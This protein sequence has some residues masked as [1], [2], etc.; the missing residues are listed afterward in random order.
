M[1]AYTSID[2]PSVYFQTVLYTGNGGTGRNITLD[3]NSDLQPDWIWI[4]SRSVADAP[5]MFDSVR[6]ATKRLI[7]SA[8]SEESTETQEVSAFNTDGFTIGNSDNANKNTATFVA[9]NW[10]AGTSFTNDASATSIGTIDSTGSASNTSGFSVV[11]YTGTGSS[12]T[13]K[14]GLSTAPSMVIIKNRSHNNKSWIIAQKSIGYAN[15][16]FLNLSDAKAS[17]TSAFNSTAPTSSV[18]T[19]GTTSLVNDSGDNYIA[20]CFADVK[21]YSKV[22]GSYTGNGNADGA[23]IYTGFKPAFFMAKRTDANDM[24]WVMIDNKR[25]SFNALSNTLLANS[26]EV[27]N[28]GTDRA[29]FL[30]QGVKIKTTSTAWNASGAAFIFMAFA[31]SPFVSSSGVPTTAR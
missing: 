5:I 17:E 29:D 13:I 21:G 24:P 22:S 14:H 4:K 28:T 20:Y 27:A 3:G 16:I 30:S 15:G 10:K 8:G 12:G 9:W 23:F 18:F 31:E 19:V 11:S 1:A 25:N 6:G 7:P 26:D 2:D